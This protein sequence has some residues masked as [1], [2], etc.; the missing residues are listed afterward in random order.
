MILLLL[1][2]LVSRSSLT[3]DLQAQV[4]VLSTIN[5]PHPFLRAPDS[6]PDVRRTGRSFVCVAPSVAPGRT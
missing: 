3:G 5:H 2:A 6:G 4:P 1:A